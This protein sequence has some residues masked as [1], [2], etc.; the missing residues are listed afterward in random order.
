VLFGGVPKSLKSQMVINI[1]I[2]CAIRGEYVGIVSAEMSFRAMLERAIASIALVPIKSMARGTI[3]EFEEEVILREGGKLVGNLAIDDEGLPELG[4]VQARATDLK[5]RHPKMTLL[6]VDY[7]QLIQNRMMGKRG[8]EEINQVTRGLKKCSKRLEVVTLAPA[9]ANFKEV[10]KRADPRVLP[11]DYQGASGMA[12][13]GD[14]VISIHNPVMY[15]PTASPTLELNC[16]L[17]RRTPSWTAYLPYDPNT[18]A[19]YEKQK[20]VRAIA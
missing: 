12:Q 17:S 10:N 5:A 11:E 2:N 1:A 20:P 7:V 3:T 18:L 8:D 19:I 6:V 16:Q 14:F 15:D 9:Q 4:D 13:D